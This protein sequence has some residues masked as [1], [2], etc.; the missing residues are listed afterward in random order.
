MSEKPSLRSG[1]K[2]FFLTSPFIELYGV[3]QS[4]GIASCGDADDGC[5]TVFKL[6]PPATQGGSWTEGF[7][8]AFQGGSDGN[9]PQASATVVGTKVYGTT[10]Y[11]GTGYCSSDGDTGCGTVFQVTQ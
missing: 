4:G 8:Y 5:G 1:E 7:L 3:T 6:N 9:L 10:I 11:G 2:C